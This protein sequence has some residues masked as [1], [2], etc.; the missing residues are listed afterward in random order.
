MRKYKNGEIIKAFHKPLNELNFVLSG[1]ILKNSIKKHSTIKGF[2][3]INHY[4]NSENSSQSSQKSDKSFNSRHKALHAHNKPKSELKILKEDLLLSDRQF[5][6]EYGPNSF[7]AEIDLLMNAEA[8]QN[9]IL[10]AK[11]GNDNNSCQI[12]TILLPGLINCISVNMME[13]IQEN[14][15]PSLSIKDKNSK[16]DI[17]S[18]RVICYLGK[19]SYGKV[20]LMRINEEIY[21]VKAISKKMINKKRIL[22]DYLYE[23]K[24]CMEG[25]LSPFI[26]S[27][28]G[29]FSDSSYCYFIQEYVEGENLRCLSER[30]VLRYR[31]EECIFYFANIMIMLEHLKQKQ[32]IHR[33][34]KT[35][36][37]ILMKTGYLKLLDFGLSKITRDFAYTVIGSPFYMAP[38]VILGKGYDRSCDFWSSGIILFELFYG[39]FPFG[40]NCYT[41]L[42]VYNQ[43]IN[44]ELIFPIID[45]ECGTFEI[46]GMI[47][48]LLSKNI[49]E[50]FSTLRECREAF[51]K[52]DW[53][54]LMD[55]NLDPPLRPTNTSLVYYNPED[56][57]SNIILK[58]KTG[59]H[60]NYDYMMKDNK[61]FEDDFCEPEDKDFLK[62]F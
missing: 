61:S 58:D 34:L 18:G 30:Y 3:T 31:K 60:F 50:R 5:I 20:N 25:L 47:R 1:S 55:M 8:G 12:L 54:G 7:I 40:K 45:L 37:M 29:T 28:K 51:N 56:K 16:M 46:N 6:C 21:A 17:T 59:V 4:I 36:N 49:R 48:K 38:E 53:D 32:I 44:N 14:L 33:D 2:Q 41:T 43:I 52:F 15:I 23:E 13:F 11:D 35:S 39:C 24:K 10:E 22:V 62:N 42:E 9:F 57:N 19:G 27:L 26:V